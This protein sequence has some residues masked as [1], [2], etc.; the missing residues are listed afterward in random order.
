MK[1]DA[2]LK[3]V[4]LTLS[5]YIIES[6]LRDSIVFHIAIVFKYPYISRKYCWIPRKRTI[7]TNDK[8]IYSTIMI[9]DDVEGILDGTRPFFLF[10]MSFYIF[11]YGK[12]KEQEKNRG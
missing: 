5:I 11:V 6:L 2:R 4:R 3:A 9:K 10:S 12:L 8:R 7:L 1:K